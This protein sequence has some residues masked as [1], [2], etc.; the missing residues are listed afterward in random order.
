MALVESMES[1]LGI[2]MLDGKMADVA[3]CMAS[4][5]T[6]PYPVVRRVVPGAGPPGSAADVEALLPLYL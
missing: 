4:S 1:R 3:G 5:A 6:F 2:L